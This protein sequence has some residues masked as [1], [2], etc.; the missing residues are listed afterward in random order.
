MTLPRPHQQRSSNE[1]RMDQPSGR[2]LEPEIIPPG[3]PLPRRGYSVWQQHDA[4]DVRRIYVRQ[5]GPV[6]ATLL[7]LGIGA[8][9]AIF[10]MFLLGAA[11]IG[12]LTIGALTLAGMIAGILRGP[13][14]PLR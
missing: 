8:A 6:G 11:L 3:A 9:A 2:Q 12:L 1:A 14:R 13:P 5:I 4:A 10:V 7:T